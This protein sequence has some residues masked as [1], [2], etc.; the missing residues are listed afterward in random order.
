MDPQ[1]DKK[2]YFGKAYICPGRFASY[3]YQ[4]SEVIKLEPGNV[5]EVGVGNGLVSYMLKKA[6]LEITTLD[7]APSLEPD[8]VGSILEMS[9]PDGAF[10]LVA[11]FEVLEH[12]PFEKFQESLENIYRVSKRYA[13]ISL[14]DCKP[15][16]RIYL[17]KI[18]RRRFLLEL[19]FFSPPEHK[20][21]GQHFWEINKK[22]YPLQTILR[23]MKKVG[24]K[25][26][27]TYRIWE[28]PYNRMFVLEKTHSS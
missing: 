27:K 6:G 12:L 3:S 5:L 8:I 13:V 9:F 24:F 25:L 19:P 14:P 22:G 1:V 20:F 28:N 15:A 10:D 21:N 7:I 11:C 26:N 23:I 16:C 17:S 2:F 18:G 4:I